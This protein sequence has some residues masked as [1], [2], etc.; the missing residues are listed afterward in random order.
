M[1]IPRSAQ[2]FKRLDELELT[3]CLLFNRASHRR[4]IQRFFAAVSRLGD[5]VFW[6]ALMLTFVVLDGS[7]GLQAALHMG[8]VSLAGLAIYKYLKGHLVRQRPSITWAHIRRGAAPLDR[9]SFPSGHTLHAVCFTLIALSYYPGLFWLLAPLAGLIALSRVIL[10]LHY[11]SDVAAG[12]LIGAGLA[13]GSLEL[14][15]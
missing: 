15:V 4:A 3:L 11:P 6:Y 1:A 2:L 5:G 13:L 14:L 8:L 12:A 10:G 7:G 9:Y